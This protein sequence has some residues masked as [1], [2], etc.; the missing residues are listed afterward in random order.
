MGTH[1]G[2]IKPLHYKGQIPNTYTCMTLMGMD[3]HAALS[4]ARQRATRQTAN[5]PV[6]C[7]PLAYTIAY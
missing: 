1:L 4:C 7:R 3:Q 5:Q 6:A 2:Q